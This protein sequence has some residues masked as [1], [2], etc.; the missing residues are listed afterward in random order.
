MGGEVPVPVAQLKPPGHRPHSGSGQLPQMPHKPKAPGH[1]GEE[2]PDVGPFGAGDFKSQK[3]G[4]KGEDLK[5]HD[6]ALD[7]GPA[8]DHLTFSGIFVESFSLKLG[9]T[10][11]GGDLGVVVKEA[12]LP[13]VLLG[14]P[15]PM[16]QG[17]EGLGGGVLFFLAREVS[18][19]GGEGE[20]S[21]GPIAFVQKLMDKALESGASVSCEDD[22]SG[23]KGVE[24][25]H[26]SYFFEFLF[27]LGLFFKLSDD[28]EGGDPLGFM[29]GH[30]PGR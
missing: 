8:V 24:C 26:V 5:I 19:I 14:L 28:V 25:A 18:G 6:P 17:P 10:K 13:L 23:G 21:C 7:W 1:L 27:L 30:G 15:V 29:D 22:D 20:V 11:H 16:G 9:R 12:G 3:G 4:L 2:F